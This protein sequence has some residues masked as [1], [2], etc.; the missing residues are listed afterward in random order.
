MPYDLASLQN[1]LLAGMV[2]VTAACALIEPVNTHF[3]GY[4]PFVS[5]Y[6]STQPRDA[7]DSRFDMSLVC[8]CC[9]TVM[10]HPVYTL[11]ICMI[12]LL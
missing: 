9:A 11:V 3:S 1:A 8:L 5:V 6:T 12:I 10:G 4:I 7:L 2:A